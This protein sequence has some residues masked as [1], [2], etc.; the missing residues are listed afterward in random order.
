M[1][2]AERA[3]EVRRARY[4]RTNPYKAEVRP[5]LREEIMGTKWV[6]H[7]SLLRCGPTTRP[8]PTEIPCLRSEAWGTH[9][10]SVLGELRHGA[11]R[12]LHDAQHIGVLIAAA[13]VEDDDT[14]RSL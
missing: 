2:A 7:I 6:P 13:G 3:I 8:T 14:I 11:M 9:A 4:L 1:D 5:G 12:A 10:A